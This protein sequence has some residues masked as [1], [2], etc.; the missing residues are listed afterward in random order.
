MKKIWITVLLTIAML[1]SSACAKIDCD[2]CGKAISGKAYDLSG[3]GRGIVCK[4]CYDRLW[5]R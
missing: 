4:D 1:F 2:F 5:G 3:W